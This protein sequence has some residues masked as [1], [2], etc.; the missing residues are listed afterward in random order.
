MSLMESFVE[1]LLNLR[2]MQNGHLKIQHGVFKLEDTIDFIMDT[3]K[4]KADSKGIT[5]SHSI[6]D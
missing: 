5:I 3:F 4:H 6:Q 2:L 1:D